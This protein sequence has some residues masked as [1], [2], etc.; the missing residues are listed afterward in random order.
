MYASDRNGKD[1]R[2]ALLAILAQDASAAEEINRILHD[3][4]P[5][6][7]G[8][9]GLPY[10]EKNVNIISIVL[11]APGDKINAL[12]G[13]LGRVDGVT[14]KAVYAGMKKNDSEQRTF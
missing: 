12:A 7:I 3:F 10:R 4:A 11:D 8:R 14:A 6:I 1:N 9:M 13:R 2:V 5:Y